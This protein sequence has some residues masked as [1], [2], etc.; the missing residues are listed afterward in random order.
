MDWL[1]GIDGTVRFVGLHATRILAALAMMPAFGSGPATRFTKVGLGV[2]IAVAV[3]GARPH[4]TWNDPGT[5][6]MALGLAGMRE[7]LIGLLLGWIGRS[8]LEIFRSA[9]SLISHE[10]GLN[11]A[12]QLDPVSGQPVPLIGY[13]YESAG[14]VLFFAMKAHH[15]V[16]GAITRSFD[17]VP[18]GRF[19]ADDR[20]AAAIAGFGTG[21]LEAAIRVAAPVYFVLVLLGFGIGLLAKVAPQWHVLDA[22]YPIRAGAALVLLVITFPVLQPAMEQVINIA[23]TRLDAAMGAA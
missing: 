5:D 9:G 22:A 7:V 1:N 16:L 11:T 17:L 10:M 2:M 13:M 18:P 20:L 4:D 19:A 6:P 23:V 14:L 15:A 12:N 8:I 3:A 21:M